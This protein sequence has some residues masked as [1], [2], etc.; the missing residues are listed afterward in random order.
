M[1]KR[2]SRKRS[3]LTGPLL[4][5]QF[6]SQQAFLPQGLIC[7]PCTTTLAGGRVSLKRDPAPLSRIRRQ[8]S[9][10]RR[11]YASQLTQ[12]PRGGNF[13]NEPKIPPEYRQ[14]LGHLFSFLLLTTCLPKFQRQRLLFNINNFSPLLHLVVRKA[15]FDVLIK[16]T[17]DR[18]SGLGHLF[19]ITNICPGKYRMACGTNDLL[20]T[21]DDVG[22]NSLIYARRPREDLI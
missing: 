11:S 14:L 6:A 3:G 4:G 8:E 21:S 10:N 18:D 7:P 19:S 22:H 12:E 2:L 20:A 1:W 9:F 13:L 16:P 15:Y 5:P 17:I